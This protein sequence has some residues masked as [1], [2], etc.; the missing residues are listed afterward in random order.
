[1]DGLISFG[2][3]DIHLPFVFDGTSDPGRNQL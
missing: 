2:W 3:I 1:M